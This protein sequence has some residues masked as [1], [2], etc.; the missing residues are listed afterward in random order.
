MTVEDG[1]LDEWMEKIADSDEE[2][3]EEFGEEAIRFVKQSILREK[4]LDFL[5]N[6]AKG[7]DPNA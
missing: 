4:T 6:K 7:E 3:F 1:E 2:V 5:L